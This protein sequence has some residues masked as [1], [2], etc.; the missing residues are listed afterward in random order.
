MTIEYDTMGDVTIA[1]MPMDDLDASNS[2]EFKHD[3]A[4]VLKDTTK[5][6]F[7]LGRLRFLDSSGL[8]VLISCLREMNAKGGDVKLCGMSKQV[9]TVFEL[10]RMHR[11][12]DIYGTKEEAVHA[13]AQ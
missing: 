11:I 10:V 4:P 13:F 3:V 2:W 1:I 7:D 9:R 8:G 6:V 5:L 12:F